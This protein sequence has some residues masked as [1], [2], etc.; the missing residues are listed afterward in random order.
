M[1][2]FATGFGGLMGRG[3]KSEGARRFRELFSAFLLLD[4]AFDLNSRRF[5]GMFSANYRP[6]KGPS[7]RECPFST[8][9]M[10][11]LASIGRSTLTR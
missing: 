9:S 7:R 3:G 11:Q 2:S 10:L 1:I 5:L 8:A 6:P 4:T